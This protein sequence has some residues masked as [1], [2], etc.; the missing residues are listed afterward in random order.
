MT[1]RAKNTAKSALGVQ[2]QSP[3]VDLPGDANRDTR[4][5]AALRLRI[6]GYGYAEIARRCGYTN[7][8]TAWKAIKRL[9]DHQRTDDQRAMADLQ[10]DRIEQAIVTVMESIENWAPKDKLWAVDRLAPLLKRQSELL[11]LDA[12]TKAATA[13]P[14][15]LEIPSDMAAALRGQANIPV[16]ETMRGDSTGE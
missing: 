8:G 4:A 7:P 12:P 13:G 5:E 14:T 1:R 2:G 9:R 11:G 16:M 3:I 6:I 15:I 10:S